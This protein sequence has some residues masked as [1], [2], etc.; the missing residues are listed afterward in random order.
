MGL[1]VE[2]W[3]KRKVFFYSIA[4]IILV[5]FCHG[6]SF[7]FSRDLLSKLVAP[8]NLEQENGFKELFKIL[9]DFNKDLSPESE[10][11]VRR[12][13]LTLIKINDSNPDSKIQNSAQ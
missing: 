11:F 13:V 10:K 3:M 12:L 7:G 1:I 9:S 8:N 4:V 6:P 2:V 5:V